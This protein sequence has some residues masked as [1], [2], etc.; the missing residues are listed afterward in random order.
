MVYSYPIEQESAIGKLFNVQ[1]MS[2]HDHGLVHR[3]LKT[4][5]IIEVLELAIFARA[6][7]LAS[8]TRLWSKRKFDMPKMET[9]KIEAEYMCVN[10]IMMTFPCG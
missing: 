9:L 4:A 2:A 8:S 3:Y 5:H 7:M 1:Q 6:R 10:R